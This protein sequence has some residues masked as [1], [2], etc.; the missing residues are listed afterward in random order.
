[1][2]TKITEM[3]GIK[4]PV[5]QGGMAWGAEPSLAAAVS[6]AGGLGTVTG[7]YYAPETLAQKIQEAKK[8]TT[9]PFAVNFTPGCLNL[10]E[11][12]EVCIQEKVAAVTYGRGRHTTDLVI[13]HLKSSGIRCFP[14]AGSVKHALRA[15]TEGADGVIVSGAEGGGHVGRINSLVLLAL[16]ARELRV[17]IIAAGGFADGRG[18]A[19]A[20]ALGAEA[21]QMGTRFMCTQESPANPKVKQMLLDATEEDTV[22]TGHVTGIRMRCLQ[23]QLSK[24]YEDLADKKAA[25][26]E[27]DR[28]GVGKLRAALVEGD[29]EWGSVPCGQVV[30][31]INDLPTCQALMERIM[32]EAEQALEK[33]SSLFAAQALT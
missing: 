3:M 20:L 13:T 17:P 18:V 8:L 25:P 19:A 12:L 22:V 28:V 31:L 9:R 32:A 26:S 21:V 7:S 30:G 15:Q 14:V 5:F 10:E 23:N 29:T 16:V 6:N 24:L 1:M 4:Y 11:N 27:F 2:R 33:A